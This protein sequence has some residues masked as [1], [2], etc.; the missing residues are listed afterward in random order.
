MPVEEAIKEVDRIFTTI[1]E[2]NSG[3]IDYTG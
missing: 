3:T 1:D 2:N